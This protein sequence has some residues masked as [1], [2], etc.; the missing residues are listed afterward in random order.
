[1]AYNVGNPGPG[2]GQAQKYVRVNQVNGIPMYGCSW[3][4]FVFMCFFISETP[5]IHFNYKNNL[6]SH[7]IH[8]IYTCS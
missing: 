4:L 1:M 8:L 2:L 5:K 6:G 3:V 7:N